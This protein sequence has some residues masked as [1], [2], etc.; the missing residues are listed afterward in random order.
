[1]SNGSLEEGVMTNHRFTFLL[2]IIMTGLIEVRVQFSARYISPTC[3]QHRLQAP[4]LHTYAWGA[5]PSP[6]VPNIFLILFLNSSSS[7]LSSLSLPEKRSLLI[8]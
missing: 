5:L 8:L 6:F 3:P 1:M 4:A 2:T 7:S